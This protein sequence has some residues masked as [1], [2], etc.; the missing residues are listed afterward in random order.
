MPP[1]PDSEQVFFKAC[2]RLIL[3]NPRLSR[4]SSMSSSAIL[5]DL[6]GGVYGDNSAL[7][8]LKYLTCNSKDS[9]IPKWLPP[10]VT[11]LN[12]KTLFGSRYDPFSSASGSQP[13]RKSKVVHE[14][15][16]SLEVSSIECPAHLTDLLDQAPNLKTLSINGFNNGAFGSS[17]GTAAP[18]PEDKSITW[19]TTQITVLKCRA[20][21]AIHA[22]VAGFEGFFTCFPLLVEYHDDMWSHFVSTHLVRHCPLLEVIRMQ[23]SSGASVF[24]A[25]PK[26]QP[27]RLEFIVSDSVSVLLTGLPKLRVL[28]IPHEAIAAGN[29]L[30]RPWVCLDLEEFRCQ[31]AELPFL[32]KENE[33]LAQDIRQR[34][35]AGATSSAQQQQHLT[36]NEEKRLLEI[37]ERCL[38]TRRQIMSQLSKLTSLKYLSLSPDFKIGNE[39]FDN[40]YNITLVYKSER[41]G[42]SYIR[43]N[44]VLPDTLQFRLDSGLDQLASLENLEYLSFESMDHQMGTAEIE[45]IARHFPRLKEMRGLVTENHVGMEPDPENDALVALIRSLRPDI[46]QRQSF[47]GY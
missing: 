10:S 2:V 41:D 21:R 5:Q 35:T 28:N 33:M 15:L 6:Q 42:R 19:P 38:S 34:E 1:P 13:G 45:W 32:T 25:A 16:E 22:N 14:A 4:F 18:V 12:L 39:I 17:F 46:V 36:T 30:R 23:D 24:G 11:H 29:I 3:N 8:S 44:D 37:S 40:R 43:Y 31:I 20:T 47:S 9:L 27:R 26:P 7:R